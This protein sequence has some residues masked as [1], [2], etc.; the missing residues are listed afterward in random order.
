MY[1]CWGENWPRSREGAGSFVA[2]A[3]RISG[4]RALRRQMWCKQLQ[5]VFEICQSGRCILRSTDVRTYVAG[6][7]GG[8]EDFE[9]ELARG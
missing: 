4:G 2:K 6:V 7:I 1:D 8:E 5:M 9:T 3:E